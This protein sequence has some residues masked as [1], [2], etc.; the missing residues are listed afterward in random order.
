[1]KEKNIGGI[2]TPVPPKYGYHLSDR[3]VGYS[4]LFLSLLGVGYYHFPREMKDVTVE[5]A[6]YTS[7]PDVPCDEECDIY[8]KSN[9]V[10]KL[11]GI[12]KCFQSEDPR[13]FPLKEGQ[14]FSQ[15][16][17]SPHFPWWK[18]NEIDGYTSKE[19]KTNGN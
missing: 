15:L 19:K 12:E 17:Y 16:T 1:M 11:R 14:S 18:C 6:I 2:N 7:H 4:V 10:L 5:S 9:V 8:P 13:L 3:F